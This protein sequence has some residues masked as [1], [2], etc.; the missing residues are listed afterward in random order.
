[1]APNQGRV[2]GRIGAGT[3]LRR[4]DTRVGTVE[5]LRAGGKA[6]RM[7]SSGGPELDRAGPEPEGRK[8][9]SGTGLF[10]APPPRASQGVGPGHP[11][12]A[13]ATVRRSSGCGNRDT[14]PTGSNSGTGLGLCGSC[15]TSSTVDS[16]GSRFETPC[17]EGGNAARMMGQ[18][19]QRADSETSGSDDAGPDG[20]TPAG[21]S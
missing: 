8:R 18:P 1:M 17:Q 16:A 2:R 4:G 7:Q 5:P 20:P 19:R 15:D 21:D 11:P 12:A 13:A 14:V 9:S 3:R 10:Y 6:L